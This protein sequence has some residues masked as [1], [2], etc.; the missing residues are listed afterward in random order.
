MLVPEPGPPRSQEGRGT[1]LSSGPGP[2][3]GPSS[4]SSQLT[5]GQKEKGL[6]REEGGGKAFTPAYR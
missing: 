3:L 5:T 6:E 2:L 1:C 4:P